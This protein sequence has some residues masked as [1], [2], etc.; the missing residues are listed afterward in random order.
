MERYMTAQ[1]LFGNRIT[2]ACRYCACADRVIVAEDAVLCTKKGVVAGGYHCRRY[3]YDP[4]KREPDAVPLLE[5]F[6]EKD[7]SL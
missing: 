5:E 4:L 7:F 2:P 3:R 6:R 1:T